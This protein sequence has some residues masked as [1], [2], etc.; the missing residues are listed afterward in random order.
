M[1]RAKVWGDGEKTILHGDQCQ[2]LNTYKSSPYLLARSEVE[3][4]ANLQHVER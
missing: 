3:A 4:N 2:A 1:E